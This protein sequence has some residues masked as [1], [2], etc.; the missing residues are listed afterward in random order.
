M[1]L[2]HPARTDAACARVAGG[3]RGRASAAGERDPGAALVAG[4]GRLS[5]RHHV[6]AQHRAGRRAGAEDAARR[7]AQPERRAA[8]RARG[9]AAGEPT[10]H[11][12]RTYIHAP[13][14]TSCGM[15]VIV[16]FRAV[17]SSFA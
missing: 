10:A 8:G 6:A 14:Q 16:E 5:G 13:V 3:D 12:R 7:G 17:Y 2:T 4:G 11:R 15:E 9:A 1:L